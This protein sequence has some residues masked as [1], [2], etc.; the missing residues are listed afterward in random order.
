MNKETFYFS[1]DYNARNDQKIL[2]IRSEYGNQGYA[3]FFYLLETMAEES[4]G[5]I[6]RGAIGGLS[7]GY[8]VAKEWL[9]GF[10]E[11]CINGVSILKE[12]EK[13]IYSPRMMNHKA[14]RLLLSNKG[15]EGA[16][17]RW[18][19]SQKNSPPISKERKG[20][21]NKG[22]ERKDYIITTNVAEQV[23]NSENE[24]KSLEND[25]PQYGNK[26]INDMLLAL[27]TKVH[28]SAFVDSSIERNMAKHC[29]GL[30]LNIG[31][32]EF[33]RRLDSLLKD[34]FHQ[35]NCNKIKYI[36]NNIKG[37]IEPVNRSPDLSNL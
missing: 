10:I 32:N 9:L 1:H 31:K 34:T 15:K 24:D 5:Y 16:K 35:K 18:G 30:M 26:E 8:G 12:D 29:V 27:K 20:K 22:K 21:E 13:G 6:Y 37:F 14:T 11:F 33:V 28:I 19:E 3:V 4:D 36:Y 25:K 23:Q 7:L 17:K 2:S